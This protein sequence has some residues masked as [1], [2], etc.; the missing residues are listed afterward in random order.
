[1]RGHMRNS[2]GFLVCAVFLAGCTPPGNSTAG[3]GQKQALQIRWQRLVDEKG[4]TC[5]RC[6]A[7]EAATGDAVKKLRR[8]LKGLDIEVVLEKVALSPSAFAKDP[9]ESNRIWIAEKPIEEWLQGTIGKSQCCGACGDAECRT[10][11]VDGRT[12]DTIPAEL[13]IKAGLLASAQLIGSKPVNPR[14]PTAGWSQ[15]SPACC[16]ATS[17]GQKK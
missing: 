1:M 5:A 4:Q 13:I 12:Y 2:I 7:T 16:P 11:T 17:G 15:G 6:G 3:K 14:D 9:L 10:L 8:S